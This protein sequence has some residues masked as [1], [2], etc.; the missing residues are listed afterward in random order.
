[1]SISGYAIPGI[2]ISIAVVSLISVIS[3]L[4]NINLKSIFIGSFFGL[5]IGYF[6]RFYSIAFNGIKSNYL[7]IHQNIDESGYLIGLSKLNIFFR[8]HLPIL[9][10]KIHFLFLYLLH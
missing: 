8:I 9:K 2:L 6:F 1:M 4:T 7:K 5:I 10:E 3:D